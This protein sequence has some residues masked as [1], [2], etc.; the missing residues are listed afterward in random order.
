MAKSTIPVG[1]V[2]AAIVE[3]A[4]QEVGASFERFCLTGGIAALAGMME[5]TRL[6]CAASAM[7]VMTTRM[8]IG[9]GR[10]RESSGSTGAK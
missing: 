6:G 8:G 5:E 9:G 4:C 10:P 3:E 7:V 2:P 1:V